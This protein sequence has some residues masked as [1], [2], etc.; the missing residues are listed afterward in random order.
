MIRSRGVSLR[1]EELGLNRLTVRVR[2]RPM[3]SKVKRRF[4]PSMV[5]REVVGYAFTVAM[6]MDATP[7]ETRR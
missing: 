5:S 6:Y 4:T 3:P 1:L 7:D 2:D